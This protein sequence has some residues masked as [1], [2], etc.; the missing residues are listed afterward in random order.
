MWQSKVLKVYPYKYWS[1][2]VT[3]LVGGFQTAF[4]GIILRR[5]KNAWMLGWD[6]NLV[7]VVYSVC[8][9]TFLSIEINW[10]ESYT[11]N[12][13]STKL[14]FLYFVVSTE[15]YIQKYVCKKHSVMCFHDGPLK[16]E[17]NCITQQSRIYKMILEQWWRIFRKC[18]EPN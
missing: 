6:L 11:K 9:R 16:L 4:V 1:S 13:L 3:C 17:I 12:Y 10:T 15:A 18:N 5:D 7:T 8:L 2:M 14:L